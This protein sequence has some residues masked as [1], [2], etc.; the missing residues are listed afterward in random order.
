VSED[1]GHPVGYRLISARDP[2]HTYH[3]PD[4]FWADPDVAAAAQTLRKVRDEPD[5]GAERARAEAL[6]RFSPTAYASRVQDV[7]GLKPVP[8]A[9][10]PAAGHA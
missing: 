9:S 6:A 5:G 1:T 4:L 2:Q 7:L 8:A 3:F 10:G